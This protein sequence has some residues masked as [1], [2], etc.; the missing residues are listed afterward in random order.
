MLLGK[1]TNCFILSVKLINM[2]LPQLDAIN[3]TIFTYLDPGSAY[4]DNADA[5]AKKASEESPKRNKP[6]AGG[7]GRRGQEVYHHANYVNH[8]V[9]DRD[10]YYES[11]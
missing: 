5:V 3:D 11:K 8:L 9:L 2:I 10:F 6:M 7:P 1:L 4:N